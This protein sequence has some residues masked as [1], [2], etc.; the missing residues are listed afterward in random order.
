MTS[1][2]TL[3][4]QLCLYMVD[5]YWG[6]AFGVHFSPGIVMVRHADPVL[7]ELHDPGLVRAHRLD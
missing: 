5:S 3:S 4:G 2:T 6:L 1:E 7:S